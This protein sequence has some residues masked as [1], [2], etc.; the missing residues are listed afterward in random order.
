[1]RGEQ[2]W[3]LHHPMARLLHMQCTLLEEEET[4]LGRHFQAATY[5]FQSF[6]TRAAMQ[7]KMLHDAV[8]GPCGVL[9]M[10]LTL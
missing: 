9:P 6:L 5:R 1:M 10:G 7:S 8:T 3:A 4:T 2:A